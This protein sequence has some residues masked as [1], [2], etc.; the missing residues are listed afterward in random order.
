MTTTTN[1]IAFS[2][3]TLKKR[4]KNG[5]VYYIHDKVDGE[6][7]ICPGNG[8]VFVARIKDGVAYYDIRVDFRA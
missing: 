3:L 5:I 4:K 6:I 2:K 1:K 7:E 8:R